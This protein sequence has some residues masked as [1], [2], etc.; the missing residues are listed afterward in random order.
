MYPKSRKIVYKASWRFVFLLQS[1]EWS[2]S[3]ATVVAVEKLA[4]YEKGANIRDRKGLPASRTS[5][6]GHLDVI[7][8]CR[9]PEKE[10]FNGTRFINNLP[11]WTKSARAHIF[12]GGCPPRSR[13]KA[14][15]NPR[16]I[17]VTTKL[18]APSFRMEG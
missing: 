4:F 2:F 12:S 6:V 14:S 7:W 3:T 18:K 11:N 8:F 13:R 9:F 15:P 16:P 5:L 17:A 10:L 1:C